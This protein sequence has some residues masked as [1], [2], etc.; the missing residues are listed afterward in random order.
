MKEKADKQATA[1]TIAQAA[2]VSKSTVSK[3]LNNCAGIDAQVKDQIVRLAKEQGYAP[4]NQQKHAQN[5]QQKILFL[6]GSHAG[7]ER[8]RTPPRDPMHIQPLF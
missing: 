5:Q 7:D 2:G 4:K 8:S 1:E 6:E 3:A